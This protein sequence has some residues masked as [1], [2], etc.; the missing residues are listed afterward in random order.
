M[1]RRVKVEMRE[2]E[3]DLVRDIKNKNIGNSFIHFKILTIQRRN[4]CQF[5]S[6]NRETFQVFSDN[7]EEVSLIFVQ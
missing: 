7:E 2:K 3:R 6:K 1:I 4:N 5:S